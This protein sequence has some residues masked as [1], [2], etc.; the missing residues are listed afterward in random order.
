MSAAASGHE[1]Q[2]SRAEV[3]GI[4]RVQIA[5]FIG[6]DGGACDDDIGDDIE[7]WD[8][9]DEDEDDTGTGDHGA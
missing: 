3:G 2:W 6:G 1:K 8:E 7:D 4:G 9:E 5:Q